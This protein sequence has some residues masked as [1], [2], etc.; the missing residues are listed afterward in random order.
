MRK[1]LT[2]DAIWYRQDLNNALESHKS[3]FALFFL[4]RNN[5][6]RCFNYVC[7]LN[8]TA[9]IVFEKPTTII[10][11]KT[12]RVKFQVFLNKTKHNPDRWDIFELLS[13]F[14]FNGIFVG[15]IWISL[16]YDFLLWVTDNLGKSC[17]SFT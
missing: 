3:G 15:P 4:S 2:F 6:R 7:R 5:Y 16:L 1:Q 14:G 12:H 9:F 13:L 10:E 8:P 17:L 11:W